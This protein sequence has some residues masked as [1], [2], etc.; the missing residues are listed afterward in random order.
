MRE[1]ERRQSTHL[2]EERGCDP[3]LE[4]EPPAQVHA[5]DL[6]EEGR[7]VPIIRARHVRV[8]AEEK[9]HQLAKVRVVVVEVRATAPVGRE[10]A[11]L[12]RLEARGDREP[13]PEQRHRPLHGQL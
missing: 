4:H 13:R 5:A 3:G 6:P 12:A 1:L 10:V 7:R 9:R 2:V 8:V 11:L